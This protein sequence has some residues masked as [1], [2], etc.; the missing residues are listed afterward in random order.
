MSSIEEIR[1][2]RLEKMETLRAKGIDPY[3]IESNQEF[4]L[5]EVFNNFSKLSKRKKPISIVGRVM[6]L[7]PQGGLVFLHLNDGTISFQGLIKKDDV[8]EESFKLF[9]ETV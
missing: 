9:A 1:K 5:E 7:R 4:T 8:G 2:V 6:S 3:P